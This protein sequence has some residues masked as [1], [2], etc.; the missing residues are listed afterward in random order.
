MIISREEQL[1]QQLAEA[2]KPK[3][4][5]ERA[6]DVAATVGKYALGAGAL[7]AGGYALSRPGVRE[8]IGSM[9]K[10]AMDFFNEARSERPIGVNVVDLSAISPRGQSSELTSPANPVGKANLPAIE[11]EGAAA[12]QSRLQN[13]YAEMEDRARGASAQEEYAAKQPAPK[14]SEFLKSKAA[15]A[16]PVVQKAVETAE[17]VAPAKTP[18]NTDRVLGE[19]KQA[20]ADRGSQVQN[21]MGEALEQNI[22]KTGE[23]VLKAFLNDEGYTVD[24]QATQ[25]MDV[26]GYQEVKPHRQAAQRQG[27]DLARIDNAADTDL[28]TPNPRAADNDWENRGSMDPVE[29]FDNPNPITD[30]QTSTQP[31]KR[32]LATELRSAIAASNE[33]DRKLGRLVGNYIDESAKDLGRMRE[34]IDQGVQAAD[35]A[36]M[37]KATMVAPSRKPDNVDRMLAETKPPS[38]PIGERMSAG[39]DRGLP[40]R[41]S[42]RDMHMKTSEAL[43]I[44]TDQPAEAFLESKSQQKRGYAPGASF[45]SP[46]PYGFR[47]QAASSEPTIFKG[48]TQPSEAASRPVSPTQAVAEVASTPGASQGDIE[49]TAKQVGNALIEKTKKRRP[50]YYSQYGTSTSSMQ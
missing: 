15:E 31:Q 46:D 17:R 43:G 30:G 36:V 18:D 39:I 20:M 9:G 10:G 2:K 37:R 35:D 5:L 8:K 50:G 14:T 7:A 13:V 40:E 19:V 25:A 21:R 6:G 11:A 34:A 12:T 42:F 16:A 22:Q 4:M 47:Q 3:N 29:N 1:E 28:G 48:T 27:A 45:V 23:S 33:A 26:D 24:D 32:G 44:A 38:A 41:D 49:Q